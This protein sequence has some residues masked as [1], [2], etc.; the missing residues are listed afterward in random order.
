MGF[1][2]VVQENGYDV[3]LAGPDCKLTPDSVNSLRNRRSRKLLQ[4][5]IPATDLFWC[6]TEFLFVTIKCKFQYSDPLIR[7]SSSS[8]K[9]FISMSSTVMP[10]ADPACAMKMSFGNVSSFASNLILSPM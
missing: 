2:K 4:H 9:P 5:L 8:S 3:S 7:S 10:W 6:D 1:V